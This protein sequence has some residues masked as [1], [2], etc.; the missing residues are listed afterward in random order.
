MNI[1][2]CEEFY[3]RICKGDTVKILCEKFEI[4]EFNILRNNNKIPL[5]VGEMVKIEKKKY[6]THKVQP[7]ETLKIISENY[8]IDI[9][10]LKAI[11]NLT[12]DKLYIGQTIKIK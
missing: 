5:Y 10:D 11:N 7:L 1:E 8:G 4:E 3:Y 6:I 9:E 2:W 12:T